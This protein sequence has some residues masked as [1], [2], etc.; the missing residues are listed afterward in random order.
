MTSLGDLRDMRDDGTEFWRF[1]DIR[2]LLGYTG[3]QPARRSLTRLAELYPED[4]VRVERG[5]ADVPERA[6]SGWKGGSVRIDFELTARGLLLFVLNGLAPAR[7]SIIEQLMPVM[8][9][10]IYDIVPAAI[11]LDRKGYLYALELSSGTVKVGMSQDP[12]K[13]VATHRTHAAS[14]GL[15]ILRTWVSRHPFA[16]SFA[17]ETTA[18]DIA[19]TLAG[20]RPTRDR[21]ETFP[22]L[23][24]D[25]LTRRLDRL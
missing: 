17:T 9:G 24:F 23:D 5:N 2:E 12:A 25:E 21:R 11:P 10:A 6:A 4:V 18:L 8:A 7:E 19:H 14:V 13:R 3:T 1:W 15:T 20:T 16:D 22:K